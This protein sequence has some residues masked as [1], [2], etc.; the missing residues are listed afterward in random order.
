LLEAGCGKERRLVAGEGRGGSGPSRDLL[1]EPGG[2]MRGFSSPSRGLLVAGEVGGWS[3]ARVEAG[4]RRAA[5]LD[6][7]CGWRLR[8]GGDWELGGVG[9]RQ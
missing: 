3:P 2:R 6:A 9:T 5:S 1:L 4:R 8:E 7:A